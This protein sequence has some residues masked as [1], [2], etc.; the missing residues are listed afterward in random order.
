M[1]IAQTLRR[2][3]HEKT[4]SDINAFFKQLAHLAMANSHGSGGGNDKDLLACMTCEI[5]ESRLK[6]RRRRIIRV[7]PNQKWH[8]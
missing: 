8:Q 3:E 6:S 7:A 2:S 4:Y 1:Y 5:G